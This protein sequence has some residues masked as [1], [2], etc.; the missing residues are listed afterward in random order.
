MRNPSMLCFVWFVMRCTLQC[1]DQVRKTHNQLFALFPHANISSCLKLHCLN[2]F[3]MKSPFEYWQGPPVDS[4]STQIKQFS[5]TDTPSQTQI[6]A[7]R[8]GGGGSYCLCNLFPPE[9]Q[10]SF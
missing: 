7:T 8:L 2:F 9:L 5:R 6:L 1:G 4:S 10:S 3:L